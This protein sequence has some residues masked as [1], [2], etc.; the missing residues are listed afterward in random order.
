MRYNIPVNLAVLMGEIVNIIL[1]SDEIDEDD[2]GVWGTL[3]GEYIQVTWEDLADV[4][5]CIYTDNSTR[6]DIQQFMEERGKA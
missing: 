4:R 2:K 6:T 1:R 5:D 3:N